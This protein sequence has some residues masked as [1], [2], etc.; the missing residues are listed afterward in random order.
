MDAH[1]RG[2][3]VSLAVLGGLFGTLIAAAANDK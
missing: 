3:I 1:K 2:V